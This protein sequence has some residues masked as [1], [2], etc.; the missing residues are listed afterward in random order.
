MAVAIDFFFAIVDGNM[1]MCNIP[2]FHMSHK[3]TIKTPIG[4]AKAWMKQ[5]TPGI[6]HAEA[7]NLNVN[8]LNV[9]MKGDHTPSNASG[10][11]ESPNNFSNK[12][13]NV[14]S[15]TLHCEYMP[16]EA[17]FSG[18]ANFCTKEACFSLIGSS[19]AA[20]TSRKGCCVAL[21]A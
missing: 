19:P 9:R 11:S 16:R 13:W 7:E 21:A 6:G 14:P 1:S 20:K 10:R 5:P 17:A 2:A 3:G 8:F 15:A 12:A 18:I 4:P